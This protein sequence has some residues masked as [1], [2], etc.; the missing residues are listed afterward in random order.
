MSRL[1]PTI[2]DPAT[3][4]ARSTSQPSLTPAALFHICARDGLIAALD[5]GGTIAL[6]DAVTLALHG[7]TP[8]GA[9]P[10]ATS[11]AL[12]TLHGRSVVLCGTASGGIRWFDGADLTEIA[13]P[14]RFAER[15]EPADFTPDRR[16]WPGPAAVTSLAVLGSTVISAV[17]DHVTCA[18]TT[19]G[20]PTGPTLTH[21]AK[22]LAITPAVL[23]GRAVVATSCADNTLRTWDITTGRQTLTVPIPWPVRQ[24]VSVT[25][26]QIT[27]LDDGRLVTVRAS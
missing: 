18:D 6:W 23:D 9:V 4:Q 22:I 1:A 17:G 10:H 2:V 3:G 25:T 14:G 15:S 27:I 16:G 20:E 19:S 8:I 11:L 7:S 26:D 24:I 21:P 13:P 5:A 12:G